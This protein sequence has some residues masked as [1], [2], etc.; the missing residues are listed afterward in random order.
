MLENKKQVNIIRGLRT[1]EWLK[2]QLLKSVAA[3]FVSLTEGCI[4]SAVNALADIMIGCYL[5]ARRLNVS[6]I[7]LELALEEKVRYSRE[8]G[9]ELE[10]NHGDISDL[11]HYLRSRHKE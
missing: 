3:V 7:Q 10:R 11:L 1:L 6:F 2:N 4:E 5:L 9:H 8:Q